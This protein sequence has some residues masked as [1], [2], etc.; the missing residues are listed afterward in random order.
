MNYFKYQQSGS[1]G[2]VWS[3][4]SGLQDVSVEEKLHKS[5]YSCSY[6]HTLDIIKSALSGSITM[7]DSFNL[8]A[9]E[10]RCAENEK[11]GMFKKA[12]KFLNIVDS[13]DEDDGVGFG[14]VSSKKLKSVE[15][16]FENIENSDAFYRNLMSLLNIRDVYIKEHGIDLVSV[17]SSSLKGIPESVNQIKNLISKNS[18]LCDT[19]VSLCE[20]SSNSSL[21]RELEVV[22]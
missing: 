9:Y 13:V 22:I 2:M 10:F 15:T 3:L 17:L 1:L 11:K 7:D 18:T 19:I 8:E 14:D 21:I 16:D 6:E 12:E 20:T 5:K 4:F